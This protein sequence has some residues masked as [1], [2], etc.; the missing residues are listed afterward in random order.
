MIT[1]ILDTE[2][3]HPEWY[4]RPLYI[5]V[6]IAEGGVLILDLSD[7]WLFY[8]GYLSNKTLVMPAKL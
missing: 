4:N 6:T 7:D 1:Y 2:A 8:F 3:C 5:A